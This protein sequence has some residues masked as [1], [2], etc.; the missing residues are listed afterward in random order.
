MR[1]LLY[2]W[3]DVGRISL[4]DFEVDVIPDNTS[5]IL[6]AAVYGSFVEG[7]IAEPRSGYLQPGIL[8]VL[9]LTRTMR[10]REPRGELKCEIPI[11]K[12]KRR[13]WGGCY[14]PK[15]GFLSRLR[16]S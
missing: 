11:G 6:G 1:K 16:L 13:E 2:Q 5:W 14:S 12:E 3:V 10:V 7:A 9:L 8:G 4:I 15:S